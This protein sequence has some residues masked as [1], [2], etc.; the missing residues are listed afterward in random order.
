MYR[1]AGLGDKG[2]TFIFSD[3]EIKYEA[4]LEFMNNVLSVGEVA[5]LFPKDEL[6]EIITN[7]VPILK[8]EKPKMPPTQ[9]N[10]YNYFIERARNHLHIVLCFS[11]VKIL[12]LIEF[13]T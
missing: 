10:C 11:P 12:N 7:M 2:V 13:I 1:T 4:F 6:D 8:K 9:D 5:N 3:N